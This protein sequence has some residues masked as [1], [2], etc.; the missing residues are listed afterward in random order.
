MQEKGRDFTRFITKD[1]IKLVTIK[2]A[3]R[4]K[5]FP[6]NVTR[7]LYYSTGFT[8]LIKFIL[9]S[10]WLNDPRTQTIHKAKLTSK[11]I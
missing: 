6:T 10:Q 5:K 9:T 7:D 4:R 11:Q 2:A 3:L 1:K 8:Q